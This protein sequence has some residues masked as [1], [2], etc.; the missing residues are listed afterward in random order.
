MPGRGPAPKDPD[1]YTRAGNRAK[2]EAS[3]LH[4]PLRR[5]EAREL[6]DDLLPAGK[7]WHP[8]T[9]R[10]WAA[11]RD[12]VLSR[13]WTDTEWSELE[14][15][16][17]LHNR[18]MADTNTMV[19]AELRQRMAKFGATSEDRARLR[20]VLADADEREQRPAKGAGATR[21]GNL[22]ELVAMD[23]GPGEADGESASG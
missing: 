15:T 12:S 8:A 9:K 20:I 7:T 4:L 18:F 13:D 6:P 14:V 19:A 10:W 1:R 5:A 11:W 23:P 2:A 21:Y 16:A 3:I 17:K 22:R